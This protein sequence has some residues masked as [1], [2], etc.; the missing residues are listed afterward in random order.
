M[1]RVSWGKTGK[2]FRR[3]SVPVLVTGGAGFLGRFIAGALNDLGHPVTVLDNLSS[4]NSTFD[5][6]E[7]ADRPLECI[8]GSVFD[9]ALMRGLVSCHPM[10]VHF[11]TVVGVEETISHTVPTIENLMGTLNLVKNLTANHVVL[12]ASSADVYGAHSRL[13]DRPMRESDYFVFEHAA[14]NRWVYPHV[15]ALEEN[16]ISNS[17]ARSVVIRVFNTYGPEMDFPL[18]KRVVPHFLAN[19]LTESPL[20]LS[21]DGSQTRSFCHVDDMI[22]GMI[23]ALDYAATHPGPVAECFNLGNDAAISIRQLAEKMVAAALDLELIPQPLPIRKD[24]FRYSQGFDDKWNR[25]PD[26]SHARRILG[27]NPAIALDDGLRR[28]LQYCWRAGLKEKLCGDPAARVEAL[29]G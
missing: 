12:F 20:L 22:D 21:G 7:L 23:R 28:T 18:P 6:P 29:V 14:V 9:A 5:C 4:P 2:N 15:K 19:I 17:A 1:K 3:R 24:A 8:E 13:Y 16:L 26:L 11:A 25:I 10:I 27:Y